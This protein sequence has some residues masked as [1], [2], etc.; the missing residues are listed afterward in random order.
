LQPI[1]TA[2]QAHGGSLGGDDSDGTDEGGETPRLSL[3]HLADS[4]SES[5]SES[6][7]GRGGGGGGVSSSAPD[8]VEQNMVRKGDRI[9]YQ[10]NVAAKRN[11]EPVY[12]WFG[13]K[14]LSHR[15]G[16]N[17]A[18]WYKVAFD[19]GETKEMMF[20][21][22]NGPG[23]GDDRQVWRHEAQ[24]QQKRVLSPSD[25][26]RGAGA[27]VDEYSTSDG[28]ESDESEESDEYSASGSSSDEVVAG[29][30]KRK[31]V[32]SYDPSLEASRPQ[33]KASRLGSVRGQKQRRRSWEDTEESAAEMAMTEAAW[34]AS[35]RVGSKL[36]A[37]DESSSG[38]YRAKV[39]ALRGDSADSKVQ[40]HYEGWNTKHDFWTGRLATNLRRRGDSAK[41]PRARHTSTRRA[42]SS[43][44]GED[45]E[46]DED[47][48][49]E[50]DE[51]DEEDEDDD[52]DESLIDLSDKNAVEAL[53][54]G[55]RRR[56][57]VNYA[58]GSP[59]AAGQ[60][61]SSLTR[62]ESGTK[63][64]WSEAELRKLQGLVQADGPSDWEHKAQKFRNRTAKSLLSQYY[65][66][67]EE[68]EG[69]GEGEGED[70]DEDGDISTRASPRSGARGELEESMLQEVASAEVVAVLQSQGITT[71][72][73]L[74]GLSPDI[75]PTLAMMGIASENDIKHAIQAA[76]EELES[77][78]SSDEDEDSEDDR[79]D[80][81]PPALAS[82]S[83]PRDWS[84]A[85]LSA[86]E[87]MVVE[88]GASDW[89]AKATQLG[90]GRSG[91]AVQSKWIKMRAR[92]PG[93][94]SADAAARSDTTVDGSDDDDAP[95]AF[96][97][98]RKSA[99]GASGGDNPKKK[100]KQAA[101][102]GALPAE[103]D[104][105][106]PSSVADDASH[107][108]VAAAA[109]AAG[110]ASA[111]IDALFAMETD[112]VS[113]LGRGARR[114]GR[115]NY[116]DNLSERAWL[117]SVENGEAGRPAGPKRTAGQMHIDT[118]TG[119]GLPL[120]QLPSV[121]ESF[122]IPAQMRQART[123]ESQAADRGAE[124]EGKSLSLYNAPEQQWRDATVV[125]W[126]ETDRKHGANAKHLPCVFMPYSDF[127]PDKVRTKE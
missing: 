4:E 46:D 38:W 85:E 97:P 8:T 114:K 92:R 112:D 9:E 116:N 21:R 64:A 35:L 63:A 16:S 57:P 22:G 40:V 33:L 15:Q 23:S 84:E 51:D 108:D 79:E 120:L 12:H 76:R 45:G 73:Q 52:D 101:L 58:D 11:Q 119:F 122:E 87:K 100:Q 67:R 99:S 36:Q 44:A 107:S 90:T 71:L 19:D 95:L 50:D 78:G 103:D 105:T 24:P 66:H 56:S 5:E 31:A 41:G 39:K 49:D 60:S 121:V 25:Q 117:Q 53:Q 125:R 18:N 10:F 47:D 82:R 94:T 110:T 80:N 43:V 6:G 7:D 83:S 62:T 54:H 98:T 3:E 42:H 86:L 17:W 70:D 28:G 96:V 111:P 109:E 102:K 1:R 20:K 104:R 48:E 77:S 88:N 123:H 91:K 127:C 118:A 59:R 126:R 124:L 68:W 72:E 106:V 2:A 13:G 32:A 30:R 65:K 61:E 34:L 69:E 26:F 89:E 113:Q 55:L 27:A 93:P 37:W 115:V 74:A 14:V 29:P 81:Q 75:V